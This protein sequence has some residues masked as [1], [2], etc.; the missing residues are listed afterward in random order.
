[1]VKIIYQRK[2]DNGI[3][4]VHP[5][6]KENLE[7][8]FGSLNDAE[9]INKIIELSIPKDALNIKVVDDSFIPEDREF[10]DAWK[11]NAQKKIEV[12]IDAAKEIKIK[13]LEVK[14]KERVQE[15]KEMMDK[16]LSSGDDVTYAELLAKQNS[17]LSVDDEINALNSLEQVKAMKPTKLEEKLDKSKLEAQIIKNVRE[18]EQKLQDKEKQV[19]QKEAE[20]TGA[21]AAI[22]GFLQLLPAMNET[23]LAIKNSL[24]Q[25]KSTN[26]K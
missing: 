14:K 19:N 16:A 22:S 11:L 2:S 8:S 13:Q 9:Y 24:E 3:S 15:I 26:I 7:L 12:D 5:V 4:V 10:R 1:M 17:I 21:L 20:F 25:N 18:K 6:A 23:L